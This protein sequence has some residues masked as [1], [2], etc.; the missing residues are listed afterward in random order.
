MTSVVLAGDT[1]RLTL[2]GWSPLLAFKKRVEVPLAH[3]RRAEVGV[4][5]EARAWLRGSLRLPGT[6]LPG[7]IVAGSY[8]KQ[9]RWTFWDIR[10]GTR[11]ITIWLDGDARW[12]AIVVDV[13]DPEAAVARINARR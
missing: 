7:V 9:G 8:R 2:R 10:S 6:H 1:L 5:P 11:A 12:D 13:A 3:V 4:A